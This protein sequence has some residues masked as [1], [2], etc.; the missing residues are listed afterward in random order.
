M[1]K[2]LLVLLLSLILLPLV[3]SYSNKKIESD[4]VLL[5]QCIKSNHCEIINRKKQFKNDRE[6]FC[7]SMVD[8]F[9]EFDIEKRTLIVDKDYTLDDSSRIVLWI[10]GEVLN[11]NKL[12]KLITPILIEE[13]LDDSILKLTIND[14]LYTLQPNQSVIDSI[15][16]INKTGEDSIK[17]TTVYE[18]INQGLL[19]RN[20]VYDWAERTKREIRNREI[21]D[22]IELEDIKMNR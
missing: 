14:H 4:K 16:V 3:F 20:N 21:R 5:V 22:S 8:D 18:I 15:F 13:L 6:I 12:P 1:K 17:Y 9:T 2:P 7:I 10:P 11:L 19:P